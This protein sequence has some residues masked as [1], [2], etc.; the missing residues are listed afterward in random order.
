MPGWLSVSFVTFDLSSLSQTVTNA[1]LRL[2]Y[3]D[4]LDSVVGTFDFTIFKFDGADG[5]LTLSQNGA[6][7]LAL[8]DDLGTGAVYGTGS[9]DPDPLP[10]GSA[11]DF[12]LDATAIADI[13][14]AGG[15]FTVGLRS[16]LSDV[17]ERV[18]FS[19]GGEGFVHRLIV[20]TTAVSEPATLAALALG[21]AGIGAGRRNGV[22]KSGKRADQMTRIGHTE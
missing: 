15:L 17:P 8:W 13:N 9:F 3:R 2:L 6:S 18:R 14:A 12:V 19:L 20:D 22:A 21:L 5:D 1:T 16:D 10:F 7:A 11:L 4:D